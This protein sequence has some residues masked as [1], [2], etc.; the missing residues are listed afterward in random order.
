M[1][2]KWGSPEGEDER[3]S[4]AED[5]AGEE[6]PVGE[7]G[8]VRSEGSSS[9]VVATWLHVTP[10]TAAE[11]KHSG[12][13][14]LC[15]LFYVNPASS[16]LDRMLQ[17]LPGLRSAPGFASPRQ[18]PDLLW[19]SECQLLGKRCLQVGQK[20]LHLPS[21]PQEEVHVDLVGGS[22]VP[23]HQMSVEGRANNWRR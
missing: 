3:G 6:G 4:Q 1:G 7:D 10:A 15:E 9:W 14:Q 23:G 21:R 20:K 2:A 8:E 16:C 17:Y 18:F 5:R 22:V 11:I 13:P 19:V 12:S